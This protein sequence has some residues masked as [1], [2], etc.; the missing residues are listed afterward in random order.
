MV[1]QQG[2]GAETMLNTGHNG[3]FNL[4]FPATWT[5]KSG[6]PGSKSR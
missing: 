2:S 1:K 4:A 5:D 3:T 6:F